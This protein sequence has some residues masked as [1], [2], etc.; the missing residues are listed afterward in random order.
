MAKCQIMQSINLFTT[1]RQVFAD[2]QAGTY[3]S[4]GLRPAFAGNEFP[5]PACAWFS[6]FN[7]RDFRRAALLG[8][9]TPFSAALSRELTAARTAS[10]AASSSPEKISFSALVTFVLHRLR[11]DLLR[12]RRRSATRTCF[13]ADLVTGN[14]FLLSPSI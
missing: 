3:S 1:A 4:P 2:P 5:Y 9:I 6:F 7:N 14:L 10:R 11:I 8:W 13:S 12:K